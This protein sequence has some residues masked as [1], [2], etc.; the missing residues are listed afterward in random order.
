MAITWKITKLDSN[1]ADGGVFRAHWKA[2]EDSGAE[3]LKIYGTVG[4]EPDASDS[5][6]IAYDSLTESKVLDWVWAGGVSKDETENALTAQLAAST[7][8]EGVP[9]T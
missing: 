7:T 9:W 5:D 6:F 4:F 2:I 1:N 8:S 3:K